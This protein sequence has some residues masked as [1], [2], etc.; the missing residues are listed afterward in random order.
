MI[1][2]SRLHL[3]SQEAAVNAL[4]VALFVMNTCNIRA[5]VGDDARYLLELS[6]LIKQLDQHAR[7]SS[8]IAKSA[9]DNSRETCNVDVSAR[10]DSDNSLA[11][12]VEFTCHYSR[13]CG[14]ARALGYHLLLFYQSEDGARYFI[15]G[16]ESYFVD[17]VTNKSKGIVARLLDRYSV[18]YRGYRRQAF[19]FA[20][21]Y[22]IVHTRRTCSLNSVDLD[23]RTYLLC[24]I[25]DAGDKSSA[26]Y[27]NDYCVNVVEVA[28]YFECDRSL[29]GDNILIVERM[30]EGI[31]LA[32]AKLDSSLICIIIAALDEA[33]IGTETLC[34]LDL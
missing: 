15:I 29:T 16:N 3:D 2:I 9:V 27:R 17:I 13:N 14:R 34:R 28:Q 30:N 1:E 26:A 25:R 5:A 24:G 7:G 20:V 22:R 12:Q 11:S 8:G 6:G 19:D 10:Y 32:V 23:R 21:L 18:R 33:D 31:A 4:G